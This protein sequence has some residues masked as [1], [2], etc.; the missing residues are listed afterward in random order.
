MRYFWISSEDVWFY[1]CAKSHLFHQSGIPGCVQRIHFLLLDG[2]Q[3]EKSIQNLSNSAGFGGLWI[4]SSDPGQLQFGS[5]CG[6][7]TKLKL[8]RSSSLWSQ[9]Q[10]TQWVIFNI[11]QNSIKQICFNFS[12][13]WCGRSSRSF[14]HAHHHFRSWL[15]AVEHQSH[16]DRMRKSESRPVQLPSVLHGPIRTNFLVQL[17]LVDSTHEDH[18]QPPAST[19]RHSNAIASRIFAIR[20]QFGRV[21]LFEW[22]WL[23]HLLSQRDRLLQS[24]LSP[25]Q[26]SNTVRNH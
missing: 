2:P 11:Q 4:E 21:R 3:D 25:E 9:H 6:F 20:T 16:S 1:F 17:R 13:R 10:P 12:L 19:V 24:N 26:Q 14:L 8:G 22:T 5:F 23:H 18:L 7:W 15:S